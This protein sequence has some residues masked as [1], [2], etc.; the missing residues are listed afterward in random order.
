MFM[1][2]KNEFGKGNTALYLHTSPHKQYYVFIAK[3]LENW[4]ADHLEKLEKK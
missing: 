1:D 3:C 4:M 2:Y